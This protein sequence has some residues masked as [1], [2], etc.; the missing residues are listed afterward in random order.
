MDTSDRGMLDIERFDTEPGRPLFHG[1]IEEKDLPGNW[2]SISPEQRMKL[3]LNIVGGETISDRMKF[4]IAEIG[5]TI[6]TWPQLASS[7]LHG[8]AVTAQACRLL[9][10]G[11]PVRSGRFYID[12]EQV[13]I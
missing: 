4:S 10:L 7:V 8:G 3:T 13:I 9:A 12:A 5:K 2:S 1:L 11:K 6:S